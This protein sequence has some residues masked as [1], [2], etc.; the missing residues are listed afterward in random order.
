MPSLRGIFAKLRRDDSYHALCE[1]WVYSTELTLPTQ[2]DVMNRLIRDNPHNR[3][4]QACI[5]SREGMVLS[6][7][8]LAIGLA[9]RAKNPH[10]FRPD[11]LADHLNVSKE[12]LEAFAASKALFKLRYYSNQTLMDDRHLQFMPHLADAYSTTGSGVAIYD[13]VAEQAWT[14]EQ[15]TAQIHEEPQAWKFEQNVRAVW[16]P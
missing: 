1:Y 10:V 8:R 11:L 4:G 3:R 16:V 5:G 14:S 15:F 2:D 6:D 13:C 9:T 12:L 7:V